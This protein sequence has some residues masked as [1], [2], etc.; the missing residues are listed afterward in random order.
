[1]SDLSITR[2]RGITLIEVMVSIVLMSITLLGIAGLL[3]TTTK[4]QLGVESRS[5]ISFLFNDLS[6]RIRANLDEGEAGH[7]T[8]LT[9][10]SA[11]WADQQSMGTTPGTLCGTG[12]GTGSACTRA[13]IAEL[14][15]AEIRASL[16]R[17]MAQSALQL[18]GDA[19]NGLVASFI[20]FD[21][22]F[23]ALADGEVTLNT[24]PTCDSDTADLGLMNCCP[25]AASVATT[26]GVR[27][28]NLRFRP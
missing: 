26:P 5:G 23:T 9:V 3:S 13:Q 11:S 8:G 20:W 16:A 6:G 12:S 10:A 7:Y 27:C 24:S 14:D 2:Q 25:S 28:M 21:K 1:M 15:V 17:L 19:Q 22:D 18:S 4:F